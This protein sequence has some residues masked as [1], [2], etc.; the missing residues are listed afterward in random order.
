MNPSNPNTMDEREGIIKHLKKFFAE[1]A[2]FYGA[3][4][5]FLFGSWAAGFPRQD[6]DVDIAVVFRDESFEEDCFERMTVISVLLSTELKREVSVIPIYKDF[7]KPM[8]YY[9]AIISGIPI[10][11]LDGDQFIKIKTEAIFHMEDYSIFGPEWR[12]EATR[13]NLEGL[14]RA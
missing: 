11:I 12:Y 8:L 13:R 1:K 2:S 9:N 6:S 14:K 4:M 7:R 3:E 10:W 5:S